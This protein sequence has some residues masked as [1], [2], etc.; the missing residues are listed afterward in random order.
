MIPVHEPPLDCEPDETYCM[1]PGSATFFEKP[2]AVRF[3]PEEI[4][5]RTISANDAVNPDHPPEY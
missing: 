1:L 5:F 3:S 4:S 2:S